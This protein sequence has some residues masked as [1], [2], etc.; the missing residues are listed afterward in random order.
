MTNEEKLFDYIKTKRGRKQSSLGSISYEESIKA[1]YL[2]GGC[3]VIMP[4]VWGDWNAYR[5]GHMIFFSDIKRTKIERVFL[6]MKDSFKFEDSR[7]P[8]ICHYQKILNRSVSALEIELEDEDK[9]LLQQIPI[10]SFVGK[11]ISYTVFGFIFWQMGEKKERFP[12]HIYHIRTEK[13]WQAR[14]AIGK[15]IV[16]RR[17]YKDVEEM[18]ES[19]KNTSKYNLKK[20]HCPLRTSNF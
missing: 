13:K 16:P 18:L 10:F 11:S 20:K 14:S 12:S 5:I 17:K 19:F 3:P 6:L 2:S 8:V 4:Q 15:Y 1:H 9:T 7:F